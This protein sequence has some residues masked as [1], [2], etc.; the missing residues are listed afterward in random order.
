MI[1]LAGAVG[2][3]ALVAILMR[4]SAGKVQGGMAMLAV[5]YAV[6]L[7][8][9]L[10]DAGGVIVPDGPGLGLALGL[11]TAQGALYLLGFVLMRR[12]MIRCPPS[13]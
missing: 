5:S 7:L 6:C 12:S 2:C 13:S 1:Y 3:S 4:W 10:H 8:R 9:A 11:G